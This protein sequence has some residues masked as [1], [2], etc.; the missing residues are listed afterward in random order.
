MCY[1]TNYHNQMF[2]YV[3]DVKHPKIR[4]TTKNRYTFISKGHFVFYIDCFQLLSLDIK[5][6]SVT[7]L[8]S[9]TVYR[10]FIIMRI[11]T[12]AID[13]ENL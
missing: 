6:Q 3:C 1:A 8:L 11:S 9:C 10:K 5:Q 12:C 2:F 13:I 4:S 7:V